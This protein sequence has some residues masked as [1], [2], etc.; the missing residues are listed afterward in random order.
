MSSSA[1]SISTEQANA[2]WAE[3]G[4][5]LEQIIVDDRRGRGAQVP[6][7]SLLVEMVD[8]WQ[9]KLIHIPTEF[10]QPAADYAQEYRR[11]HG[12]SLTWQDVRWGFSRMVEI[13]RAQGFTK[14]PDPHCPDC[15]GFGYRF[16]KEQR[17]G[18]FLSGTKGCIYEIA[19]PCGCAE[20]QFPAPDFSETSQILNWL[21]GEFGGVLPD[22]DRQALAAKRLFQA[23][24]S[25]REIYDCWKDLSAK[26]GKPAT[27]VEVWFGIGPWSMRREA[28]E[29]FARI[30]AASAER[31]RRQQEISTLAASMLAV[32][33]KPMTMRQMAE[34]KLKRLRLA[35]AAQANN[36]V[37]SEEQ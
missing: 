27:L 36:R 15:R 20:G 2:I 13:G 11:D 19:I 12:S 3:R 34:E 22:S 30:E 32:I 23:G 24:W 29:A 16:E 25:R 8:L 5:I 10:L 18:D 14:N 6:K 7:D 26:K 4:R 9:Q 37:D 21:A 17:G 33:E 35:E 1:G 31:K 28:A